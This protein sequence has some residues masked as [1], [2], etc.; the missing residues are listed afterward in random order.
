MKTKSC[1]E[2]QRN[3]RF[4]S[5]CPAIEWL[6]SRGDGQVGLVASVRV[7]TTPNGAVI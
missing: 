6:V 5:Q 1:R 4:Y 3:R 7:Q 2:W